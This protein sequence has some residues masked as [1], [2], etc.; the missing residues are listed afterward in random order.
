M[1]NVC[2]YM[3]QSI[4]LLLIVL[5]LFFASSCVRYLGK[6]PYD[7]GGIWISE[8]PYIRMDCTEKD[9]TQV[10]VVAFIDGIEQEVDY[11]FDNGSGFL[12]FPKNH[13]VWD[14]YYIRGNCHFSSSKFE[15]VIQDDRLY[16]GKYKKIVFYRKE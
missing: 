8:D 9:G 3:K 2:K 16:H 10:T 6:R 11:E 7:Y 13:G 4:G 5:I 15:V 14:E 1:G 12:L